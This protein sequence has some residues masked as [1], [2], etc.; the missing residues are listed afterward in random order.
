MNVHGRLAPGIVLVFLQFLAVS[1]EAQ[2]QTTGRIVGNIRDE[3]G[4]IRRRISFSGEPLHR[5]KT[6]GHQ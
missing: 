5:R 3:Q 6:Y 1:S 2:T 4:A